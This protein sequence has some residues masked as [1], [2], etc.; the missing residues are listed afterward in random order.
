L[1]DIAKQYGAGIVV[2]TIDEDGMG[3]TATKKF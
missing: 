1:L 3:R 2:G